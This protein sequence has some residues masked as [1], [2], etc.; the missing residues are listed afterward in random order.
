MLPLVM[1]F[2]LQRPRPGRLPLGGGSFASEPGRANRTAP[3]LHGSTPGR[4][5]GHAGNRILVWDAP[6]RIL[7]AAIAGT[8]TLALV[9][10]LAAD[11][12]GT[13]FALHMIAGLAAGCFI[14]LRIAWGVL[15]SRYSRLGSWPLAPGELARY[16]TG[17]MTG[18]A[19]RY[20]GHNPGTSWM[21]LMLFL[22]VGLLI[23]TGLAGEAGEEVHEVAAYG[24]LALIVLHLLGLALHTWRHRENIAWS[25]I[26]GRKSGPPESALPSSRLVAGVAV[27]ALVVVASW[28]LYRGFDAGSGQ[29]RLPFRDAPLQLGEAGGDDKSSSHHDEGRGE[30]RD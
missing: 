23:V 11:D 10:G 15:G 14:V 3:S 1:H 13:L 5:A 21:S 30:H 20:V 9:I 8:V 24:V 7:H 19:K 4:A 18:R 6:T 22:M 12:D 25:M 2:P 28:L 27:A 29:L 17:I 26:D 16:L